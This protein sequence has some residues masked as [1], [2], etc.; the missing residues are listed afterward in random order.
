MLGHHGGKLKDGRGHDAEF[1]FGGAGM[2]EE[3]F[4]FFI[5]KKNKQKTRFEI[6]LRLTG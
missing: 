5:L 2:P 1:G 6:V 4:F 3:F